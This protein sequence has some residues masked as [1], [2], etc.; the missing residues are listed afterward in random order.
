MQ[1]WT[2]GA[3]VALQRSWDGRPWPLRGSRAS[4]LDRAGRQPGHDPLL[5]DHHEDDQRHRDRDR[6]GADRADRD[7]ELRA[8][9]E[10]RD[11][12][13]HRSPRGDARQRDREQELVPGEDEREQPRGHQAGSGERQHDL[14]ERL[15]V[16]RAVDQRGLLELLRD[17][18]EER[19][20]DVDRQRQ[21]ERQER[22]DQ[23]EVGVVEA[24]VGPQ[25]EQ[26]R[27]DRDR[28]ERRDRQDDREDQELPREAQPCQRVGGE[29]ADRRA[30]S[31]SPRRRRSGSSAAPS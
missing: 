30:R 31:A 2:I 25:L 16:R 21:H 17:L 9:G 14:A 24:D 18:P 23:S 19:R 7:L 10:E 26:R 28:R 4:A 12:R 22:Q 3:Q 20:Q 29:R 8:A 1:A 27:R 5:E 6:R 11:R 13:R 15:E